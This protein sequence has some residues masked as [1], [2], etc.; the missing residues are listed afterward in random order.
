[1]Q[2]IRQ[3]EQQI[4]QIQHAGLQEKLQQGIQNLI[5]FT[6]SIFIY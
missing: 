1:M 5:F 2:A 3:R 6:L 4:Q